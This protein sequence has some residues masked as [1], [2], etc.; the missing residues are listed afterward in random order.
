MHS[1]AKNFTPGEF[2][3]YHLPSAPLFQILQSLVIFQVFSR[4]IIAQ[5]DKLR[6]EGDISMKGKDRMEI[7][8]EHRTRNN[9]IIVVRKS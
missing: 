6:E 7:S 5:W 1:L 9:K 3:C 8:I 2:Q 4:G